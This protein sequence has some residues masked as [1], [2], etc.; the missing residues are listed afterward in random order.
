M[1]TI[2]EAAKT[3]IDELILKDGLTKEHFLRVGVK[4][5]GCSG[6]RYSME[7]DDLMKEGDETFECQGI[8]IVCDK[9]SL[10]YLFGTELD[11]SDGLDG[12]GFHWKNPNASRTCNCGVSFSI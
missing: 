7:F 3:K 1:I 5:G 9:K 12:K 8:N 6:I 11:Y 2:S 10:L 4:G